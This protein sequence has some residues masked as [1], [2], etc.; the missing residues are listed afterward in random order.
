MYIKFRKDRS[1][2]FGEKFNTAWKKVV[3]RK[4]RSKYF[5]PWKI[6]KKIVITANQR[7][8]HHTEFLLFRFFE[9]DFFNRFFEVDKVGW[10]LK[11][12]YACLRVSMDVYGFLAACVCMWSMRTYL[13]LFFRYYGCLWVSMGA[14]RCLWVSGCLCMFMIFYG[15]SC[16]FSLQKWT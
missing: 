12:I 7:C 13:R 11:G 16:F 10:S 1:S 14:Y 15:Y 2:S 4:T 6:V 3:L 5:F 9:V 8:R